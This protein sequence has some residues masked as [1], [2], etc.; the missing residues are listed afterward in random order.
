M[1]IVPAIAGPA[2][3]LAT[4]YG[5]PKFSCHSMRR[6]ESQQ[7]EFTGRRQ[8]SQ[9]TERPQ[10]LRFDG[11]HTHLLARLTLFAFLDHLVVRLRG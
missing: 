3:E 4:S 10:H 9:K 6:Q 2:C 11:V 5:V 1:A 8:H 7:N